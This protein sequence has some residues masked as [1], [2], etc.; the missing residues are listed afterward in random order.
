[1][2]FLKQQAANAHHE[3]HSTQ[4][5]QLVNSCLRDKAQSQEA[6]IAR[7]R[8][9]LANYT[10][11]QRHAPLHSHEPFVLTVMRPSNPQ[12]QQE[13]LVPFD[14]FIH[15]RK[16][17][18]QRL[19]DLMA[20]KPWI[21]REASQFMK[22]RLEYSDLS[23]PNAETHSYVSPSGDYCMRKVVVMPLEGVTDT[24]RVFD[25][26]KRKLFCLEEDIS[27]ATGDTT[28]SEEEIYPDESVSQH[29][30]LRWT[31][32]G[33][34]VQSNEAV[35]S[36]FDERSNEF[37]GGN[38]YGVIAASSVD[39]DELY[40]YCPDENLQQ[41]KSS[42][43]TLHAYKRPAVKD[44]NIGAR[45]RARVGVV[46]TRC[47]FIKLRSSKLRVSPEDMQETLER[48]AR[49]GDVLFR[50]VRSALVPSFGVPRPNSLE[51]TI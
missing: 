9:A 51:P 17:K 29:H 24:K 20:V 3:I 40:P 35:F 4:K 31:P 2:D 42:V 46:L 18:T 36:C 33:F 49:R 38:D 43:I 11:C 48:V 6:D 32:T 30:L 23:V 34:H 1:V 19:E 13:Q 10:V 45:T 37:G 16:H 21:L 15:L 12:A 50:T 7:V 8:S 44:P 25:T 28:V 22:H 14:S 5:Q 26:L 39:K 27:K 47:C 41:D